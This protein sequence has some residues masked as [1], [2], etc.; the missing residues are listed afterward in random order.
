MPVTCVGTVYALFSIPTSLWRRWVSVGEKN[1]SRRETKVEIESVCIARL[2]NDCREL[3]GLS[4]A[5]LPK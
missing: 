4:Y 1:N 2:C 3:I 5:Q